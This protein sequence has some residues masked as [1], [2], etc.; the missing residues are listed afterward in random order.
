MWMV[1]SAGANALHHIHSHP[2]PGDFRDYLCRTESRTEDKIERLGVTHTGSFLR[3]DQSHLG[4]LG[5]NL[6]TV[7]APSI[8]ADLDHHLIA[9]M[10][11]MQPDL[12]SR[13][14]AQAPPLLA[15]SMP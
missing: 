13:R 11:G 4:R 12:P 2:A 3:A 15:G 10:K 5:A 1:A 14:L 7:N 6:L 9:L 8:V